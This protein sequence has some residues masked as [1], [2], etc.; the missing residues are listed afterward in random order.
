VRPAAAPD[1]QG[2]MRRL[3]LFHRCVMGFVGL[4]DRWLQMSCRSFTRLASVR[5]ERPL[6][7]PE[8]LRHTLHWAICRFWRLQDRRMAQLRILAHE[9]GSGLDDDGRAEL[10]AEA[11]ER[12]RRAMAQAAG[13]AGG[14]ASAGGSERDPG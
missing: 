1:P 6:R 13:R 14:G 12:I 2:K 10:S 7:G 5:H 8:R 11:V 9:I 3:P 4:F